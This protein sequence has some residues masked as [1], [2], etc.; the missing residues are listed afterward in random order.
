MLRSRAVKTLT[1]E[2]SRRVPCG[3]REIPHYSAADQ[4]YCECA[5][6]TARIRKVRY[7]AMYGRTR[8]SLVLISC[9]SRNPVSVEYLICGDVSPP[10]LQSIHRS[11]VSILLL[12]LHRETCVVQQ[13]KI[14]TT[15]ALHYITLKVIYSGLKY[16]TAKT[17]YTVCRTVATVNR[18]DYSVLVAII[19]G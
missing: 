4:Y 18:K 10:E 17:L 13:Q 9:P 5:L 19:Q 16:R 6:I 15:G 8:V 12:K 14:T 2:L 3:T 1:A 11:V 7:V